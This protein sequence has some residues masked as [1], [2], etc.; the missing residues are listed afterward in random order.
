MIRITATDLPRFIACNGYL[1]LGKAETSNNDNDTA[2]QEGNAAHWLIEKVFRKEHTFDELVD[3]KAANGVFITADMVEHCKNYMNDIEGK[4]ETELKTSY[5]TDRYC[6]SGR[7]DHIQYEN[8]VLYVSDFKYGWR[9]VEPSVNWT[10][11]SHAVGWSLH[12]QGKQVDYIVFRIYQP[13]PYHPQGSKREWR[14]TK[15]E[16]IN[17]YKEIDRRLSSPDHLLHTGSHCYKCPSL[18]VCPAA[19]IATMNAI[20]VSENAFTS[21]IDDVSLS[22]VMDW[23]KRSMQVLSQAE[24][25]YED[26]AKA[27]LKRG[28]I[29]PN[30]S[31]DISLGNTA[32]NE[33]VTPELIKT[34]TGVDVVKETMITPNQA[35]SKGVPESFLK[36]LTSRE[37]KGMKLLRIDSSKKAEKLFGKKN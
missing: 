33:G 20:E 23:I 16:L 4:G 7:A 9:I 27:R 26:I 17:Y 5:E 3:R 35:K 6:V 34:M 22:Y 10:L 32:W 29:I 18:G 13:R 28:C 11:I 19:Q 8:N 21:D 31:L 25:A 14:I 2:A 37:N 15:D 24:Q 12:N 1:D 30:Y 36:I